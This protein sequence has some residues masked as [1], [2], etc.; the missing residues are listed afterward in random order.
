MRERRRD[1]RFNLNGKLTLEFAGRIET[2]FVADISVSGVGV[3]MDRPVFGMRPNG[4]VGRCLVES[5]DLATSVNAYVSIMR[6]RRIGKRFLL[7]LRFESIS[8]QQLRIVRAY[9]SLLTARRN[10]MLDQENG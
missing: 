6:V 4:I 10:R 7:G 9:E 3:M 1:L 8:D 5:P 2:F